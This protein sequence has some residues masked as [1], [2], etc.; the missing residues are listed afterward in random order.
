MVMARPE[1]SWTLP[2]PDVAIGPAHRSVCNPSGLSPLWAQE[3][4][5]HMAGF[6]QRLWLLVTAKACARAAFHPLHRSVFELAF[7]RVRKHG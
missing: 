5:L 4:T 2:M 1:T 7:I 3:P 6:R